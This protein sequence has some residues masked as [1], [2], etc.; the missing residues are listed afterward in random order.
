MRMYRKKEESQDY[1]IYEYLCEDFQLPYTGIIEINKKTLET[2]LIKPA[3]GEWSGERARIYA[4]TTLP[5]AD[6]PE[7]YTHTAV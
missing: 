5:N 1:I 4:M 6:Y 2:K 3:D 7:I